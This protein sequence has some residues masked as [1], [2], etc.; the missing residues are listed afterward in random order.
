[1]TSVKNLLTLFLLVATMPCAIWAQL[2]PQDKLYQTILSKD[3][4]LFNVGFNTCDIKP[5]ETLFSDRFEFF[6]D[7]DSV[8][9]KSVF[10][11]KI[12]SGLCGSPDTYQSRRE[13]VEGSTVIYPLYKNKRLYGVIQVGIHRFFETIKGQPERFAST[14]RFTHVWVQEQGNWVLLRSLSYD[15]QV[16]QT[17][18]NLSNLFDN[19]AA[20]EQWLRDKKVPTL[21][22]GIIKA[23]KLQQIK[24]Y[25]ELQK[26]ITA[27]YNTLF[28]VASLTKPITAMVTLRLVSQNKWDLDMPLAKYWTDPDVAKDPN[29]KLITTRHVL[30]HQSGFTNWRGNNADGKLHFDFVPGTQYRYSG[31]GFEYLRRALEAKFRKTLDVL[32]EE[33]IFKPLKMD[34]TRFFWDKTTDSTRFARGYDR[35]GKAY[36][37]HRNTKP[38]A[39]DDLLTTVEDYGRFLASVMANDGLTPKVAK[40][41][42]TPQVASKSGKHFGLGWEIYTMGKD[43]YVLSHGGADEGVQTIVFLVPKTQQGLIIFTNVDDGYKVYETILR[44]YLSDYAQPIIDME[45]K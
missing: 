23:G 6:H 43:D 3:S 33:L 1:M 41:M 42:I 24:L 5:F 14:A 9:D 31:E 29:S 45:T 16:N 20:V 22:I 30:S 27:P 38:N 39:A 19:D 4:L 21:G 37:I 12:K 26:G 44:H 8:C 18:A 15:H 36:R 2:A 28:N 34:D 32:A 13:L 11:A 40:D 35:T 25:G 10:I 17:A 7:K